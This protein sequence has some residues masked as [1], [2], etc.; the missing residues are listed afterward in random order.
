MELGGILKLSNFAMEAMIDQLRPY[1]ERVDI[2][3]YAAARN[4][5]KLQD[6][7]QDY[8]DKRQEIIKKYGHEILDDNGIPTGEWV[9]EKDTDG[10]KAALE[11]INSIGPLEQSI[12]LFKVPIEKTIGLL[13]GNDIL[14]LDFMLEEEGEQCILN[15]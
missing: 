2:I 15:Q 1:L 5:R 3:G 7:C 11:V 8:I 12:E 10:Y 9:V 6:G 4:I 13:S 14:T